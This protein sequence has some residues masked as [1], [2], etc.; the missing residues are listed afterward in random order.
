MRVLFY[1]VISFSILLSS[2]KRESIESN[3]NSCILSY[4][5]QPIEFENFN[6]QR[7]DLELNAG[8]GF[9]A[10]G[11]KNME[12]ID[13]YNY[14]IYLDFQIDSSKNYKLHKINFGTN[15]KTSPTSYYNKVY[16]ASLTQGFNDTNLQHTTTTNGASVKG[17]FSGE[18]KSLF[19]ENIEVS[20]GSFHLDF[21]T[22]IDY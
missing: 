3:P 9:R 16:F 17:G 20:N 14:Y 4:C 1:F 2:C 13:G 12:N 19:N 6:I 11:K 21:K 7:T 10:Y 5:G 22:A 8:W 18:L 15:K